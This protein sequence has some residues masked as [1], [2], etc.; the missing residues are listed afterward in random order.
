MAKRIK[1]ASF[2]VNSIKARLENFLDWLKVSNPDI[3]LLQEI[4]CLEENFPIEAIFDAGYNS[5]ILGQKSYNGVAILS[6]YKIE[7]VTKGIPNYKSQYPQFVNEQSLDLFQENSDEQSQQ[8]RYIEGIIAIDDKIIRVA[9]VYV[10]NGGGSLEDG[11]RLEDSQKFNYKWT[12][13][14]KISQRRSGMHLRKQN[15]CCQ[16]DS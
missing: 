9:S 5:A 2:N 10:P 6:K 4:K 11:Q 15:F 12:Y 13:A 16:K 1:I 3:V 7:E 14:R 8:A